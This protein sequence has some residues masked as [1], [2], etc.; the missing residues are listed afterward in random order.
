MKNLL[1]LNCILFSIS[2][3][4]QEQGIT[5]LSIELDSSI[6]QLYKESHALLIGVADY[7]HG[8]PKL[9]GVKKDIELV[10]NALIRHGFNTI[11]VENP[12]RLD[13]ERAIGIFISQY[14]QE[15]QNRILIYFAGH[16]HTITTSYGEELGYI[17]PA[18]A[19]D[20]N[21]DPAGFKNLAMPMS[22]VEIFAKQMDSKHAL[23]VFDACFSGSLFSIPRAIPDVI[24][25]KTTQPVRQFITSGSANENVPDESIFC[26]QLVTALT[27]NEADANRD[28]Y[29]TGT[30]LGEF[31]QTNVINYSYN[32]QH[33]QYGK[34]K[35]PNLDKGDFV[36]VV[37]NTLSPET[38]G[39]TYIPRILRTQKFTAY[40]FTGLYIQW[41]LNYRK[42]A[43][44][45]KLS[46][47]YSSKYL[48]N[49]YCMGIDLNLASIDYVYSIET[50]PGLV[51]EDTTRYSFKSIG[52]YNRLYLFPQNR[53]IIN[54]YVG[55]SISWNNWQFELGFRPFLTRRFMIELQSSYIIQNG[56][57]TN[58]TFNYLGD[59]EEVSK[60][61]SFRGFYIGFNLLYF[62][63]FK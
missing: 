13:M 45:T 26:Q 11:V 63:P 23:F 56:Q 15:S 51:T 55:S 47:F 53:S 18:N 29:L 54:L 3:F 37:D 1:F 42:N 17:I 39:E 35:N 44:S 60:E 21:I 38:P 36:F 6:K 22:Q 20:P 34:I 14:A 46:L 32:A 9:A 49:R 10:K 50:F 59:S 33:P 25:Y 61:M 31:I 48:D 16:G 62:I 41:N 12:T 5:K 2:A 40:R 43:Y 57:V 8:W 52:L 30:E 7:T 27:T 58:Q 28:G 24:S 19:P 4:S